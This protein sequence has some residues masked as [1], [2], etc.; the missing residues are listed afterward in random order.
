MRVGVGVE[1]GESSVLQC[2]GDLDEK[3]VPS[4]YRVR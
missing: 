2:F 3:D 4:K 1:V